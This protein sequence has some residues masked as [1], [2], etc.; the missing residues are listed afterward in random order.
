MENLAQGLI[1]ELTR[2]RELLAAYKEIPTGAFG[3]VTT[4]AIL[5]GFVLLLVPGIYLAFAFLLVYQVAV[6]ERVFAVSAMRRS[7]ELMSGNLL[8]GVGLMIVV[9]LVSTVITL[10]VSFTIGLIPMAGTLAVAVVAA[11]TMAFQSAVLIVLYFDLRCRKE[12]FD[13]EHLA[14][15]VEQASA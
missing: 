11:V 7:R 5:A 8:R 4:L 1:R 10:A 15:S 6:I 13:L 3:I 2:N 12:A 9:G 14:R